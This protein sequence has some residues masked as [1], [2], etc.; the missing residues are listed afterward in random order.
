MPR[1]VG[2][3]AGG[4]RIAVPPGRGTRPTSDRT[5]EALFS[6]LGALTDLD[7]AHV[8]DLYAGSGAVGLE[9]AS[10]GA[11]HVLSVESDRG[12]LGVLRRNVA[13]LGLPGVQVAATPVERLAGTTGGSPPYDVVFADPPYAL[14]AD[15]LARVLTDL[16]GAGW[17]AG[18]AVVVVER[19]SR[20][21]D[22]VWPTPLVAERARRYGEATLWYGRRS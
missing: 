8:L 20:D 14:A 6:A 3:A 1:I 13:D 7:G 12:A 21:P 18:D 17:L 15:A 11:A 5:R 22:W 2:G 4:R 9:A 19:S 10:R 16:D